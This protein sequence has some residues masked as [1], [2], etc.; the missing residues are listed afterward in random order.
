MPNERIK[1]VILLTQRNVLIQRDENKY[2]G[3][4]LSN[5]A[6]IRYVW[7]VTLSVFYFVTTSII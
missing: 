1:N 3:I 7:F 5:K 6:C 2:I 4:T